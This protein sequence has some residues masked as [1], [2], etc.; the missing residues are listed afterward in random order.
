LLFA[1]QPPTECDVFGSMPICKESKMSDTYEAAGKDMQQKTAKKLIGGKSHFPLLIP[2]RVVLP[3]EGHVFAIEIQQ[4]MIADSDAM[5]IAGKI[6][7]DVFWS[8]KRWLRIDDPIFPAQLIQ[9]SLKL[10]RITEILQASAE[11]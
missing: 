1:D 5:R 4:L 7:Q 3:A 8:A 11:D 9:K 10:I 2:V 6:V